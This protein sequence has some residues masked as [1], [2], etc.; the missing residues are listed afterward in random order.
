MKAY[1][2]KTDLL[3]FG[4]WFGFNDGEQALMFETF[5]KREALSVL[6]MANA[7][8]KSRAPGWRF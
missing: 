7:L 8:I 6:A 1:I 3:T 4:V 5:N 2:K